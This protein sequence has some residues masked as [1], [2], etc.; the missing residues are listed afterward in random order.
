MKFIR[1]AANDRSVPTSTLVPC[2][3]CDSTEIRVFV[4]HL[5][6]DGRALR[7][8]D[9]AGEMVGPGADGRRPQTPR[10]LL[11]R[12]DALLTNHERILAEH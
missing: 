4:A 12:L 9:I 8:V 6:G 10:S 11:A 5:V 3:V 1:P 7:R 2:P